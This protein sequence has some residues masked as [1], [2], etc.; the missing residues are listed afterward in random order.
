MRYFSVQ[1]ARFIQDIR[2]DN[3]KN[4]IIAIQMITKKLQDIRLQANTVRFA[5]LK[6]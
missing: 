5:T 6:P 3:I 2:D 4:K 1:E